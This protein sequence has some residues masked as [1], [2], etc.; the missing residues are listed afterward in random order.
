MQ[1]QGGECIE[2]GFNLEKLA[3]S[4][5][6]TSSQ[7]R[8]ELAQREALESGT[9]ADAEACEGVERVPVMRMG[10]ASTVAGCGNER[11]GATMLTLFDASVVVECAE[12]G[13]TANDDDAGR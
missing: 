10:L 6:R 1:R 2:K 13:Y 11:L 7:W 9:G 5:R 3:R 4:A 12:K 8:Y